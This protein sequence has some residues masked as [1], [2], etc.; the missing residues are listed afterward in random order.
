[1]SSPPITIESSISLPDPSMRKNEDLGPEPGSPSELPNPVSGMILES[2]RSSSESL[3]SCGSK[4][5]ELAVPEVRPKEDVLLYAGSPN[6]PV[7]ALDH[8]C[9]HDQSSSEPSA[10]G[11]K[12]A[13]ICLP[14]QDQLAPCNDQGND[15]Q[16]L[17]IACIA[18]CSNDRDRLASLF[19]QK[20]QIT[21]EKATDGMW[22]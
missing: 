21:V 8:D 12:N 5:P 18:R 3:A 10:C 11:S 4:N 15:R 13:E 7:L 9:D 14:L 19:A 16:V 20:A 1:M 22:I 2:D 17:M 6:L